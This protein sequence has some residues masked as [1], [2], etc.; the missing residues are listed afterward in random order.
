MAG[1]RA[2]HVRAAVLQDRHIHLVPIEVGASDGNRTQ[3]V[4]GLSP[5]ELVVVDPPAELGDG[6]VVQP[7]MQ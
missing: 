7:S 1:E 5:G 3:V 4:S 6:A 2:G